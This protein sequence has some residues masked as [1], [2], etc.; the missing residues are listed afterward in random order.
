MQFGGGPT[1]AC[2]CFHKVSISRLRGEAL[3]R[4]GLRWYGDC[5]SG[6]KGQCAVRRYEFLFNSVE[7]ESTNGEV[8]LGSS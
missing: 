1:L 7:T 4:R 2:A 6:S 5:S 8:H 3:V